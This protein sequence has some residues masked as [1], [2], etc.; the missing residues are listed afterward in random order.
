MAVGSIAQH[1]A[2]DS[3][4]AGIRREVLAALRNELWR[5][6][7][8]KLAVHDGVVSIRGVVKA[9]NARKAAIVAAESVPGVRK[10]QD[11]LRVT[12]APPPPEDEFGGG[13]FVSLQEQPSTADDEPL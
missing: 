7:G 3:D 4:D 13:D 10:V 9:Q 2:D 11:Y 8:L 6:R 1:A 5:P 12:P